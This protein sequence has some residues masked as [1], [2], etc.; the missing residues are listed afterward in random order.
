M[1]RYSE[2][3][4]AQETAANYLETAL[5]WRSVF[6]WKQEDLGPASLL[7]RESKQEVVLSRDVFAAL[8]RL[9][10]NLPDSAYADALR[11]LT[12]VSST[13]SL[14]QTNKEL[15]T[16]LRDGIR[17]RYT[18]VNGQRQTKTLRV[19]DF[20]T[21]TN[22]D[23][24]VVR[25]LQV[26]G[27]LGNKRA[28][29]VGFI[30]G[31]P[32]VFIECK[33]PK[34][35]LRGA[36][37]KNFSDYKKT[38]PQLFHHNAI[39]LFMNGIDAKIGSLTSSWEHFND[40]KRLAEADPGAVDNETLLKGVCDKANLL[41]L[42]ENFIAFD[43]G[44]GKLKKIVARNHQ[45][46]GV[47]RAVQAVADRKAR[48][49][50]LGVFWHTQ[51]AGKSYSMVFFTRK[52]HRKLGGQFTFLMLTDRA[53]LD[54]QLYKTFAGCDVVDHDKDPCRAANGDHLH[55]LLGQHKAYIF[56][57]IQKFNKDEAARQGYTQ[58]DDVIVIT[59]EAHRTQYGNLALNLRNALPNA[60]YMGFTGT[61]L[62]KD[63]EITRRI[64]GDYV[65]TYNF[66]RA[67][68]DGATLPLYYDSR[69]EKLNL[70]MGDLNAKIAA[71]LDDWYVDDIDTQQ[72]LER[73]LGR[74]YHIITAERRLEQI[75]QDFV[76]HYSRGWE[77]GKAMFVCIDKLTAV[78]MHGLIQTA[79]AQQIR[80]L[81]RSIRK[82][83]DE[84][85]EIV[86]LKQIKW[87]RE[88][89]MAVVV[90]EEQNEAEKFAKWGLDIAPHRELL[91]KGF[92]GEGEK[93][94]SVESAFKNEA[95]PLR[96]AIV[97]A[98]WLTGFDVP[99]L[100]T[101]YL[102]KPLKAHTLMQAIARA[103][104]VNAGKHNGLVVDY[105][106]I[107]EHLREAL[108]TFAHDADSLDDLPEPAKPQEELLEDLA[109]AIDLV[110]EFLRERG[111]SLDDV[112]H[113][114]TEGYQLSGAIKRCK[115][116][117]N[118]SD[119]SRKRFEIMCRL[120][121]KLYK[122]CL[123]VP[124]VQAH[125]AERKAIDFLYTT[126]QA[127]RNH[128]DISGIIKQLHGIVDAAIEPVGD[129]QLGEE[130]HPY[131]LSGIDFEKLREEFKKGDQKRTIVQSLRAVIEKRLQILLMRNPMRM[132]MQEKY[133]QMVADYNKSKDALTVEQA[134]QWLEDFEGKL[135][136]EEKRAVRE[137]LDEE[138]LAIFDLLN[139]ATLS[140]ADRKRIKAIAVELLTKLKADTLQVDQ[141]QQ[142]D[143]TSSAVYT[144]IYDHLFD[145]SSGLPEPH[146]SI[147]DIERHSKNVY[148]HVYEKYP[149]V[150]SP[151]YEDRP[152]AG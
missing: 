29:L 6:A 14:V 4:L 103:N 21:P 81:E 135:S 31:L 96:V 35:E 93:R 118:E 87:M 13:Q 17:V 34:V 147:E 126:L 72:R 133:E 54:T 73:E 53:D 109:E 45:F 102:D 41:D 122:A 92:D 63:D 68:E 20:A 28:D 78:K 42:I 60:S 144:T 59:D 142:K 139:K 75:A 55:S 22:N 67:I 95:H 26:H 108:A 83:R 98:M 84:Q 57:L 117:A 11:Q 113:L 7:G 132:D 101:L 114:P 77:S 131:D 150:P 16:L 33:S 15:Y 18:A 97:C 69:G 112:M 80:A 152:L 91:N 145:E 116:A 76:Q 94:I 129:T 58:R 149:T 105:C 66:Q 71:T 32:L 64:F 134:F 99:S 104:R 49:G 52:V 50:K 110:R 9:N 121:F 25:E 39:V 70:S 124:G 40:W 44:G 2:D 125:R 100:S 127:D 120:V 88:T 65:S 27:P 148:R 90:S 137:N 36:F 61:P 1:S 10:P 115:E 123:N 37:E 138:T 82:T 12:T 107:L 130:T 46:L 111:A 24:L 85:E 8:K 89:Q 143:A 3:K 140:K 128:A 86:I 51:G 47:N 23:F 48:Q 119:E 5:G 19:L 106:G 74:S 56:S 141:W 136:G 43:D 30:N 38:V 146:Y 151:Y 79:W 62:F